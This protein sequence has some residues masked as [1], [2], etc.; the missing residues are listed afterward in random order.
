VKL[1]I[2]VSIEFKIIEQLVKQHIEC[3]KYIA[4]DSSYLVEFFLSFYFRSRGIETYSLQHGMYFKYTNGTPFDAINYENACADELL[5]WLMF[6]KS[7]IEGLIL[8]SSSVRI[9]CYLDSKFPN[10]VYSITIY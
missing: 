2:A 1:L 3:D 10:N 6:S 8:K 5:V 4:F 7:E 9:F